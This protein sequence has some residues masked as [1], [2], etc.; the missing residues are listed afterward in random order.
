MRLSPEYKQHFCLRDKDRKQDTKAT[1]DQ[2]CHF[3]PNRAYMCGCPHSICIDSGPVTLKLVCGLSFAL[4]LLCSLLLLVVQAGC[5]QR[6]GHEMSSLN[7]STRFGWTAIGVE[8]SCSSQGEGPGTIKRH[9]TIVN[10]CS[11]FSLVNTWRRML[12]FAGKRVQCGA[13]NSHRL[14]Q[15]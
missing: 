3:S 2:K 10:T 9:D 13:G 1:Q 11:Q 14:Q 4:H 8:F 15:I 7:A 5:W 12:L 6:H